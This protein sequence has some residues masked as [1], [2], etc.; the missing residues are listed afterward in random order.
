MEYARH[1]IPTARPGGFALNMLT[2]MAT[3]VAA[4]GD[5]N[6]GVRKSG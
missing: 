4:L 3:R 1:S 6:L 5:E 2:L